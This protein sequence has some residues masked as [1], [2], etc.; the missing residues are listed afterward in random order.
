MEQRQVDWPSFGVCLG[1]IVF[2]CVPLAAFPDAGGRL[3]ERCYDLIAGR[4]GFAYLLAGIGTTVLLAWLAFGRHGSVVL[5]VDDAPPEYSTYSWVAMLFCAGIGAGLLAW[6]PIEWAYYFDAPPFGA[7][8]RSAE[9]AAW[10][11]TYGI[12]HWGP[13]AWCFYCLPTIAI[14]YPYYTKR[15]TYLRFSASCHYFLGAREE[16]RRAR[17]IDGLFMLALLG[18]AGSS[19]GFSTPLNRRVRQPPDWRRQLLRARARR[20]WPLRRALWHQR[21]VRDPEGHQASQRRQRRARARV[22]RRRRRRRTCRVSRRDLTQQRRP[23]DLGVP[24]HEQLDRAVRQ[25]R[26][27]RELDDLL[28]GVV[29]RVRPV[30]RSVRHP[31]LARPHHS[32]GHSRHGRVGHVGRRTVLHG[33]G[34]LRP[35]SPAH[36]RAG[37]VAGARCRGGPGRH[38]G[39]A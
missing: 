7:E 3:L 36:G 37:R 24:P 20:R 31:H 11:S 25:L 4:L 17:V 15:L 2:V 9:A 10:A 13:T 34:K 22:A 5:G 16:T 12:F 18:G 33:S 19:L 1:I 32:P 27:R 39:H 28:L 14:A 8:A 26:V 30:R 35:A 6:A 21:L 29:D 23:A 38:R